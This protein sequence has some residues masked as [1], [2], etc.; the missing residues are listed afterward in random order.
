MPWGN[1]HP[2]RVKLLQ[3]LHSDGE[4]L[5]VREKIVFLAS[6]IAGFALAA[7]RIHGEK[8]GAFQAVAHLAVGYWFACGYRCHERRYA[9][10]AWVLSLVELACF[11]AFKIKGG[12]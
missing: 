9:V 11:I 6:C 2:D 12:A 3:A 8:G 4:D 5:D 1:G 7:M 10:L